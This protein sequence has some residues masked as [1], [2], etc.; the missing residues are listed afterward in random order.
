MVKS[1]IKKKLLIISGIAL[2]ML[3]AF[4]GI[5]LNAMIDKSDSEHEAKYDN[6]AL[7]FGTTK[8]IEKCRNEKL[9]DVIC[10]HIVSSASV[11]ECEGMTC[12]IIYGKDKNGNGFSASIVVKQDGKGLKASDYTRNTGSLDN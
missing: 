3:L 8:L 2:I 11:S 10:Y 9:S 4:A 6:K 12:W 5:R 1:E 7:Q